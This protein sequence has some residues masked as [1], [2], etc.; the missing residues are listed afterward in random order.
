M[1][2]DRPTDRNRP[3]RGMWTRALAFAGLPLAALLLVACG[4][5]TDGAAGGGGASG[6]D[7][8]SA[9]G[10]VLG[11]DT[12]VP[13]R[14]A[15]VAPDA[16]VAPDTAA[17]PDVP[18]IDVP[19]ASDTPSPADVPRPPDVPS[20]PDVP[21]PPSCGY[22]DV[23]G[24]VCS[25]SGTVYI[26]DALVYVETI[27]CQGQPI[28]VET[29]SDA[30][31]EYTLT[32]V[33]SGHQTVE[34]RKGSFQHSFEV[35]VRPGQVNDLRGTLAKLCFGARAARIAVVSGT[36]DTIQEI[37][38]TLGVEYDLILDDPPLF[39]GSS[40]AADFLMDG[41]RLSE[42]HILF[43]NCSEWAWMNL[44]VYGD[45]NLIGQNLSAFVH[46]GG[47][48]YASDW[49]FAFVE[50]PWPGT[51]DFH[52]NDASEYDSKVGQMGLFTGTV[53][54]QSLATFLGKEEVDINFDLLHWVAMDSVAASATVHIEG[55]V[56]G[57][58][59][60]GTSEFNL[61]VIPLMVSFQPY[62]LGGRVLFTSFHNEQQATTDMGNILNFL[63]FNL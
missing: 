16:A 62:P 11:G 2:T 59:P 14:D 32:G 12:R 39:F 29:A 28:R 48:I 31:G 6:G 37:L 1:R 43:L 41:D 47:S 26:N 38:D 40:A 20:P 52:G 25:P 5:E 57:I 3:A 21:Q 50:R 35:D 63:V 30:N 22:G 42:Y 58:S 24:V 49:A 44:H 9:D 10:F 60:D 33:P 51:I 23:I 15:T 53:R 56:N 18:G 4:G 13:P 45:A 27:D 34:I 36:Y 17:A 19:P 7:A 54:D 55:A 8:A 61:G 46:N